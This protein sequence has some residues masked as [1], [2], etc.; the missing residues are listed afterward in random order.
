MRAP[1]V[2]LAAA[3]LAVAGCRAQQACP[4]SN[5][6]PRE[7]WGSGVIRASDLP[8]NTSG[9]PLDLTGN[10]SL[11]SSAVYLYTNVNVLLTLCAVRAVAS[12]VPNT[13]AIQVGR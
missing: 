3:A 13:V 4:P 1:A 12:S 7:F 11:T 10:F 5:V 8:F 2:A 6:V 9:L